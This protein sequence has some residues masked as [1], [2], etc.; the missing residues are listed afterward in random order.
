MAMPSGSRSLTAKLAYLM[1][2]VVMMTVAAMTIQSASKF[3][4]YI[5]QTIEET[6]TTMAERSAAEVSATIE[7][8]VGQISVATSKLS[9]A[10]VDANNNDTELAAALRTDSD[11]IALSLY[12]IIGKEAKLLRQARQSTLVNRSEIESKKI[13]D[14]SVRAIADFATQVGSGPDPF[15]DDRYIQNITPKTK[16]PTMILAI[17]FA[18]PNQPDKYAMMVAATSTTKMQIALP[19]SRYTTGYVI[20]AD[21]SIFAS[22]DEMQMTDPRP[23]TGNALIKRAQQRQSPSGFLADYSD[24]T[25]KQKLGSFAQTPG[26]IPLYV[27]VERDRKAAFQ[28]ITRTY[29]TSV[30]WGVLI[31]LVAGMAVYLSAGSVTKNLR[32]LVSA[33]K[34][35]ASGDFGVR[36]QPQSRD[37]V[38][39]LGH[40]V[41]NMASK[42]QHLLSHEVEKARFEKELETARMVQS[43]FFPKKDVSGTNLS[44][45]GSY[46]PATECGG[47]LWG[48]YHVAD[49]VEL[50]FIADAMGHGA[51]AALVTAIAYAVCQSV[52]SILKEGNSIDHS[53]ATLLRRLNS[54]ILEAV[55][56]KISMTFFAALFDFNT[57]KITFANAGHNFPFILTSDKQ[58]TRLGKA[59]KKSASQAP[60]MPITLTLQG[61]P[62]GV[63]HLSEYKE[64]SIDMAAGDKIFFFT[65]G[66]IE[67]TSKGRDPL[68]RKDLLDA[69]CNI[70]NQTV[71]EIKE[72]ILEVGRGIFGSEN[73][74]DDVTVVV[75]EVSK[76]WVKAAKPLIEP[77]VERGPLP[78]IPTFDIASTNPAQAGSAGAI[79]VFDLGLLEPNQPMGQPSNQ[80]QESP[81]PGITLPAS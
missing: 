30:L 23:I 63:D 60:T 24:R 11:L 38:A 20:A 77:S 26:N 43:T 80:E 42:I 76:S 54:I 4:A 3:S 45:T 17:K 19:Q 50:V 68:G 66:L 52:S 73:L 5:L 21:G 37:E 62:L 13:I 65:D 33:T 29:L 32:E 61:T 31:L 7:N 79:P 1:T 69:V 8:W 41:N 9:G 67:N 25:K 51:P 10:K 57:G 35:I 64:K 6:S 18:I 27:I 71:S 53:P 81:S 49:G 15:Q 56:G 28:I 55:D 40:S 34:R 36:L 48:H 46:Q 44:V 12:T 58:D 78:P 2:L 16:A 39:E 70:G 59:A 22:T 75:A 72:N 74:Q 47:D 14:A